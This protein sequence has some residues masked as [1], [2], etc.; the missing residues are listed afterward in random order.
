MADGSVPVCVHGNWRRLHRAPPPSAPPAPP[1]QAPAPATFRPTRT[2]AFTLVTIREN[3]AIAFGLS[4][5]HTAGRE[6]RQHAK[7]RSDQTGDHQATDPFKARSQREA[8]GDV[9]CASGRHHGD[10]VPSRGDRRPAG[11]QR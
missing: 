1:L 9:A 6:T 7:Q 11:R 5:L 10:A 3:T 2:A 8:Q 4:Q